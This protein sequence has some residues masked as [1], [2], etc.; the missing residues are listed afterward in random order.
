MDQKDVLIGTYNRHHFEQLAREEFSKT[1]GDKN[2]FCLVIVDIDDF[3]SINYRY[4]YYFGDKIIIA[5]AEIL[6]KNIRKLGLLSRYGGDGFII[7][8]PGTGFDETL[9]LM[10][11]IAEIMR[12][13][14]EIDG[15]S[16]E[17][18]FSYGIAGPEVYDDL[19]SLIVKAGREMHKRKTKNRNLIK[20]AE[21][22]CLPG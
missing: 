21:N 16:I 17:V 7:G 9:K 19:E 14:L 6:R 2:E 15:S 8:L 12:K 4:G 22:R 13:P 11:R 3:K 10:K 1:Q 20:E 18:S 5:F